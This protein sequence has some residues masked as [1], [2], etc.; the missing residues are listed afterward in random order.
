MSHRALI[1]VA[2]L[3]G[4]AVSPAWAQAE[5]AL[6]YIEAADNDPL[7][8]SGL[9]YSSGLPTQP[10]AIKALPKGLSENVKYFGIPAGQQ[11]F[12]SV[13][14]A[15]SPPKL[16]IDVAGTG[17]L[18]SVTP[19][20]GTEAPGGFWFGPVALPAGDPK[21]A[22][23]ARIRIRS[24]AGGQLLGGCAAGY[25]AGEVK[26]DGQA[27][28]VAVLD[29]NL[30]GRYEGVSLSAALSQP[31]WRADALAID[32]NQDGQFSRT[33][34]AMEVLPLTKAIRVKDAYYR[35]Q[36]A[37]NG[38]SV[39]LEKYEPKMGTLDVGAADVSLVLLSDTGVQNLA[40]AQGKWLLPEG[41]YT[42]EDLR[43]SKTD[44]AGVKWT[45]TDM[46]EYGKLGRFEIRPGETFAAKVG[47]PLSLKVDARDGQG[48]ER[49]FSLALEGAGGEQYS[50]GA[51]KG[52][53]RVPPP[54]VKIVDAAGKTL[55]EGASEYG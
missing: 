16:Y 40:G 33:P 32:L 26:L 35:V 4:A 12:W 21:G 25:M 43:L 9:M 17:D 24:V 20:V 7:T 6:K 29:K 18:S 19:L 2:C 31:L 54:K 22:G 11:R 47:P 14:D 50:V 28:R 1:V 46:S 15:S 49:A 44:A 53:G 37:P 41:A 51:L 30:D 34:D 42:M 55:A 38:S 13:L 39:R 10:P 52:S 45:L 3:L 23:T 48:G 8:A 27:Y 36:V 5:F